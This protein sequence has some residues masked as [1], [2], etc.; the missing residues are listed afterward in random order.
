MLWLR[1]AE[2]S[3]FVLRLVARCSLEGRSTLLA[4]VSHSGPHLPERPHETHY[5]RILGWLPF[6]TV[7]RRILISGA[8]FPYTPG[9][10]GRKAVPETG[11]EVPSGQN[12]LPDGSRTAP[13]P[14]N[15][16]P[17]FRALL[18]LVAGLGTG[19]ALQR[20]W[21]TTSV[22]DP[23]KETDG[24]SARSGRPPLYLAALSRMSPSAMS[25]LE[26]PVSGLRSAPLSDRPRASRRVSAAKIERTTPS[27][28]SSVLTSGASWSRL[29]VR[30]RSP[31]RLAQAGPTSLRARNPRSTIR[32]RRP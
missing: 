32:P 23:W 26:R 7:W 15:P 3:S 20:P 12:F 30:D 16:K 11:R 9:G 25:P 8:S 24:R 21:T 19:V 22:S 4:A 5:P 14:R 1:R 31:N 18:R 10:P 28:R 27:G 13:V 6:R 2:R 17:C 29:Q